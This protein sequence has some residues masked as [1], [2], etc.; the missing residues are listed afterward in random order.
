M[1][2][3]TT[4]NDAAADALGEAILYA[5]EDRAIHAVEY[6]GKEPAAPIDDG[7]S[8]CQTRIVGQFDMR[9]AG[10]EL[11]RQMIGLGWKPPA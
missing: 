3:E 10:R 8:R 7:A 1:T 11:A 2:N 5:L 9:H 6:I 4:L